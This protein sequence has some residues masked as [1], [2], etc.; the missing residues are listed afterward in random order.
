MTEGALLN[1]G[2]V[3]CE[4]DERKKRRRRTPER[5]EM[6]KTK[7]KFLKN[8]EL[9]QTKI[10]M[11]ASLFSNIN[12]LH[13]FYILTNDAHCNDSFYNAFIIHATARQVL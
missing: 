12:H 10:K 9:M 11:F 8:Y 2:D 6:E 7:S 5:E 4:E 1:I 13:N 3:R